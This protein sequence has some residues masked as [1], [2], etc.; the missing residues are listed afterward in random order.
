VIDELRIST[1]A[2]VFDA[3]AAG[4]PD[5]RQVLLLH[6]F[7]QCALQWDQQLC[8]LAG[9]GYRG[10]APDQRGYSPGVRPV[11]AAGYGLDELVGDVLRIADALG[12]ERFDL[13]GHDWGAAVSWMVAGRHPDRLRTLTAVS[14]PHPEAFVEATRGDEDQRGRRTIFAMVYTEQSPEQALLADDAAVLRRMLDPVGSRSKVDRYAARML[15][16]GAL[17]AALNWYRATRPEDARPGAITVPTLFV[18]S[19]ADTGVGPA[20]ARATA[21][22]VS[23][24]YRFEAF[25]GVSHYI[26][27]EAAGRLSTLLLAHLGDATDG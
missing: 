1:P 5:G 27:E 3:L 22:W 17:T 13:V 11:G 24:P 26:P 19:S 20:A 25:D 6:G 9:A 8:A 4:P 14:T 12:W 7:P 15:E 21:R 23:A 16:P 2:G 18:W 10:V